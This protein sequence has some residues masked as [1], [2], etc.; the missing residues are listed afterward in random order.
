MDKTKK[1]ITLILGLLF[2]ILVAVLAGC[3]RE[4]NNPEDE[5][6]KYDV[7]IKV[8]SNFGDTWIFTPDIKE[9]T[10]EFKY[11]GE[12]MNFYVDSYNLP[13]HPR[14]SKEWFKN[15]GY[16]PNTF[17]IGSYLYGD[18]YGDKQSWSKTVD[19]VLERGEYC[20]SIRA[21]STSDLW[22]YRSVHLYVTV[23]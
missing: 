7:S 1:L 16:A 6:K 20:V 17:S 23:I 3:N 2:S 18:K 5:N 10:Y 8:A 19:R 14:W 13:D 21:D 4:S 22:K 9:L 15:T 11:T 12:P